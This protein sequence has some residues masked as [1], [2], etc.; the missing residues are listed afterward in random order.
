MYIMG[1]WKFVMMEVGSFDRQPAGSQMDTNYLLFP[2]H[3]RSHEMHASVAPHI[4]AD[5]RRR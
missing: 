5:R 1:N 3:H 2:S 4:Q